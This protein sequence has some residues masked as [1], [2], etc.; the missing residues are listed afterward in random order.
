MTRCARWIIDLGPDGC[1]KG[2]ETLVVGT[3]ETVA[4]QPT[5]FTSKFLKQV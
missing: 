5:S 3:P 1:D 2:G 4:E